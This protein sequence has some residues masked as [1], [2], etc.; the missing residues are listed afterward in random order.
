M[1]W[2]FLIVLALLASCTDTKEKE[3]GKEI[4]AYVYVDY[5]GTIHIDRECV[6]KSENAKTKME[7]IAMRYGIE[8]IDTS[9]IDMGYYPYS[10]S[11][12]KEYKFCPKCI[13][14]NAYKHLR[15]IMERNETVLR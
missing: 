10:G 14:D 15:A 13:D 1:K 8:F 11:S 6:S 9:R 3:K 2:L 5:Y 7:R 4:G 12:R